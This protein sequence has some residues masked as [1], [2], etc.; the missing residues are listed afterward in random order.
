MPKTATRSDGA[1]ETLT[2]LYVVTPAQVSGAAS[3]GVDAVGH[4]DDEVGVADANSA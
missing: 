4:A 2:A 3:S 1:P